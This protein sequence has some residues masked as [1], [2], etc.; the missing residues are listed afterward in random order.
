MKHRFYTLL[1]VLI[2]VFSWEC[3]GT[4]TAQDFSVRGPC[5]VGYQVIDA[6]RPAGT[7]CRLY[8]YY[9]ATVAGRNQPIDPERAPYPLV[10]FN[11]PVVPMVSYT[12][13]LAHLA[14]WGFV[15]VAP[16]NGF[17]Q[18][19]D[20]QAIA[21]D[22]LFCRNY[23]HAEN[24]RPESPFFQ[25]LNCDRNA[26]AGHSWGGSCDIIA[27][28][29]ADER[30]KVVVAWSLW[31]NS[32]PRPIDKVNHLCCPV[33]LFNGSEDTAV[34]V[35][36]VQS[37]YDA[38]APS[39]AF[40]VLEGGG[41]N[42]FYDSKFWLPNAPPAEDRHLL[43]IARYFLTAA[44]RLYL[45]DQDDL[46]PIFWDPHTHR[47][48]NVDYT[49]DSGIQWAPHPVDISSAPGETVEIPLTLTNLTKRK[50][51]FDLEVDGS[52]WETTLTPNVT[53][54]LAPGTQ[55]QVTLQVKFP[56]NPVHSSETLRV[57]ARSQ[58]DGHTR[59]VTRLTSRLRGE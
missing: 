1:P 18:W 9:P 42:L 46:W 48:P 19:P 4:A 25:M 50:Q 54:E 5:A 47:Q 7:Y 55:S 53:A 49:W 41:H 45:C 24:Q 27:G 12:E 2:C 52:Q 8:V 26:F 3:S 6:E 14:S 15:V 57:S 58:G 30:L 38:A 59:G 29:E 11:S 34:P 39:K 28:A 35:T 36:K 40:F 13:T 16:T 51:A 31:P 32:Q 43:P 33:L 17:Y 10:V 21:R 22:L 20:Q 37:V 23:L 56:A 44:L